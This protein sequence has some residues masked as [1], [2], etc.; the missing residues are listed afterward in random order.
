MDKVIELVKSEGVPREGVLDALETV[1]AQHLPMAVASSSSTE[2]IN[3]V[4]DALD[5][6]RY[7]VELFSAEHESHGKP[8]PGVFISTAAHLNVP[9]HQCLVFEDS[10]SGVLSA[11]AA[12]MICIAVPEKE[13]VDHPY[14]QT[15][16]LVL[17]SLTE[18][19]STTFEE[20]NKV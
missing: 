20:L 14:V 13:L 17:S 6:R 2:I 12:K 3:A 1:R 19:D 16:D 11:K 4:V 8:H 5:I 7:F 18:F 15:A 10:P 9:T